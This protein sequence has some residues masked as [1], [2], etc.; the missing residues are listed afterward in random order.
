MSRPPFVSCPAA[1]DRLV[2]KRR[3]SQNP[4]NVPGLH[5]YRPRPTVTS[6]QA[7][8]LSGPAFWRKRKD[9]RKSSTVYEVGTPHRTSLSPVMQTD[10]GIFCGALSLIDTR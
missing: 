4:P 9:N 3:V 8:E 5:I 1:R 2:Q 6:H 10:R 7:E